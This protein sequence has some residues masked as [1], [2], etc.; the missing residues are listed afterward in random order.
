MNLTI[1]KIYG[2]GIWV[3]L[4]AVLGSIWHTYLVWNLMDIGSK[5][6]TVFG[7]VILQ[8]LF[9][10]MFYILWKVTPDFNMQSSN[11]DNV[12]MEKIL[13]D[14][15]IVNTKHVNTKHVNNYKITRMN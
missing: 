2:I 9:L 8:I 5:I 10:G 12:D 4:I 11:K 3:M 13:D 1:R 6:S 15:N 14:I 7:S